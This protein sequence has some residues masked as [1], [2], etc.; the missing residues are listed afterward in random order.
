MTRL[1]NLPY[2]RQLIQISGLFGANTAPITAAAANPEVKKALWIKT[3]TLVLQGLTAI[4][5]LSEGSTGTTA[6]SDYFIPGNGS[7]V[8]DGG[9]VIVLSTADDYTEVNAAYGLAGGSNVAY[10]I[11]VGGNSGLSVLGKLQLNTGYLSTRESTGL[12]Y[13]STTPGQIIINGGKLDTKQFHNPEGAAIGLI[14][15]TQTGGTVNIR[16]RFQNTI[17]Y[18]APA[19]LANPVLNTTRLANGIDATA[20]IGSFSI[21]S[22]AAN[23]YSMAGGNI[24]VYDVCNTTATAFAFFVSCPVSNINVTGGT[25]NM[26]PT[27]GTLFSRC[28]LLYQQYSFI[29]NFI[30]NRVSGAASV[31]LITNPLTVLNDLTLTSGVLIANNQDVTI[32]GNYLIAAGTTYTPGTNATIFNGDADQTF[33]VNLAAPLTL[34]KL[35]ID[36]TAGIALNFA[37]TQP[38]INVASDLRLVL[39][40]LNDNAKT[41][42]VAGNVY[43]SGIHAGAGK[44]V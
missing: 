14:S 1:L 18:T 31:Q 28:E 36:K 37:G 32:G 15:Y 12:L 7:L 19:S 30:I 10:G 39:G 33:T 38:V 41:I 23:S 21:S 20:G 25:V 29:N 9:G 27:T 42:N 44:I 24:S 35:T 11:V 16:G 40:T 3:G 8:L 2:I 22:N 26:I 17:N 6:S 13:W 34:N 4:P 5:S 43:N